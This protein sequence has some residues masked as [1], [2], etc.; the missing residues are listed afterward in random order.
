MR[1][2]PRRVVIFYDTFSVHLCKTIEMNCVIPDKIL[3]MDI[4]N[5]LLESPQTKV[6]SI[7]WI[8]SSGELV[9]DKKA[10]EY[11]LELGLIEIRTDALS[12]TNYKGEWKSA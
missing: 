2:K 7:G 9:S 8:T 6:K 3:P 10:A 12:K 1:N 5:T 4:Y 11:A